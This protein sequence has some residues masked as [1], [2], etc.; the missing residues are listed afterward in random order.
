VHAADARLWLRD[1]A[2]AVP[3]ADAWVDVRRVGRD[4]SSQPT[5]GDLG[6][7]TPAAADAETRAANVHTSPPTSICQGSHACGD[8]AQRNLQV[9]CGLPSEAPWRQGPWEHSSRLRAASLM[10]ILI[11]LSAL[12]CFCLMTDV[13]LGRPGGTLAFARGDSLRTRQRQLSMLDGFDGDDEG[14][15]GDSF[16]NENAGDSFGNDNAEDSF[17]TGNTGGS[18]GDG[19]S[20]ADALEDSSNYVGY[21]AW[22][23][24]K[25]ESIVNHTQS[26]LLGMI[27]QWNTTFSPVHVL[28]TQHK[29]WLLKNA[30]SN[31]GYLKLDAERG[32][33]QLHLH[34][35][36][37]LSSAMSQL[38]AIMPKLRQELA[39]VVNDSHA[40]VARDMELDASQGRKLIQ[41]EQIDL[42]TSAAVRHRVEAAQSLLHELQAR[43][44][45]VSQ[46]MMANALAFGHEA[47]VD[48]RSP[49]VV[50]ALHALPNKFSNRKLAVQAVR[51]EDVVKA[52]VAGE[53]RRLGAVERKEEVLVARAEA[54]ARAL[55]ASDAARALDLA[56][57][58]GEVEGGD[59]ALKRE[60]RAQA[61]RLRQVDGVDGHEDLVLVG[62]EKGVGEALARRDDPCRK[63]R[64]EVREWAQLLE[65]L[66]AKLKGIEDSY[67]V[68]MRAY[69]D[70]VEAE[71][72]NE[73]EVFE[74]RWVARRAGV[75]VEDL[76][77]ERALAV[78]TGELLEDKATREKAHLDERI[79][80]LRCVC[81]R[82]CVFVCVSTLNSAPSGPN[83]TAQPLTH[84]TLT[85]QPLTHV[86][87]LSYLTAQPLTHVTALCRGVGRASWA[88]KKLLRKT[89]HP[90]P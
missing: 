26:Q 74:Q 88:E 7:V 2:T 20:A 89:L 50:A 41:A 83:L 65:E 57:G 27:Q 55:H 4:R 61:T 37:S 68:E 18:F 44:H 34:A 59:A 25:V 5:P 53:V 10:L 85:A 1:S 79:E 90:E 48:M 82:A 56:R 58:I 60:M 49:A 72:H 71:R 42:N 70:A 78:K 45:N 36:K 39:Q 3:A 16:G 23:N 52:R 38:H 62:A 76:R 17:G 15:D 43:E 54:G 19:F 64:R 32:M 73:A 14:D 28:A 40:L 30:F 80:E 81:V 87:A 67:S 75:I 77:H 46:S 24:N 63:Q 9:P 35:S 33:Q 69:E 8:A 12:V 31:H 66:Q 6:D 51:E 21:L 29:L 84:V 13:A 47:A 86:T 11:A 22:S